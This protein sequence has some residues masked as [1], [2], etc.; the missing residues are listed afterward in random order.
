MSRPVV[1]CYH[2]VS[3]SWPA[4]VAMPESLLKSQ[5]AFFKRRGYIGLTFAEAE[6]ARLEGVLPRRSVVVTFDDGF[7]STLRARRILDELGFPATVFIV[8]HF[9]ESGELLRWP[10]IEM[11]LESKHAEELRPLSWKHLDELVECGWEVGS[12]TVSHAYLPGLN[13]ADLR[14]ELRLSKTLIEDRLGTCETVAYPYGRANERVAAVAA[15]TG[16]LAGCTF[17]PVYGIDERYRRCRVGLNRADQG[18]RLRAKLSPT[19]LAWRS[20]RIGGGLDRLRSTYRDRR[21]RMYF[22]DSGTRLAPA[23]RGSGYTETEAQ[24]IGED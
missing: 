5:L 20:S 2:A 6:H 16:Y 1:L 7:A 22:R 9:T 13:K 23:S 14:S 19:T 21:S 17:T 12:H 18:V 10:G 24:Q 8:T 15:E 3:S 4:S 11:W